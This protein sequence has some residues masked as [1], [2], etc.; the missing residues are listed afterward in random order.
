MTSQGKKPV[1]SAVKLGK[2][3]LTSKSITPTSKFTS[4][5]TSSTS[6]ALIVATLT[7]PGLE[8][9]PGITGEPVDCI[10]RVIVRNNP[11][12]DEFKNLIKKVNE[13]E[14][15]EVAIRQLRL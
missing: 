8:T 13:P 10:F 9:E 1:K 6:S 14:F 15:D 12:I 2:S 3:T 4:K 7:P 11:T 5:S